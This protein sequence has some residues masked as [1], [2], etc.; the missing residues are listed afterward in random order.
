MKTEDHVHLY[1]VPHV[2]ALTFLDVLHLDVQILKLKVNV[3]LK[4]TTIPIYT[5]LLYCV[6]NYI[7]R[8]D[9]TAENIA[10]L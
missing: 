5:V 1:F 6:I 8:S 2:H 9:Q 4:C 3:W 7:T 10:N